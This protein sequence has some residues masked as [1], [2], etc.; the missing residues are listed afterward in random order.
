M[1]ILFGRDSNITEH[2]SNNEYYQNLSFQYISFIK[3]KNH[4]SLEETLLTSSKQIIFFFKI[5]KDVEI[6]L[7]KCSKYF[8]TK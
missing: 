4:I 8:F 1:I 7:L 2:I 5:E 3:K 6:F